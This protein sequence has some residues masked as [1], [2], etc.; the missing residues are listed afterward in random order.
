MA[1]RSISGSAALLPDVRTR[2]RPLTVGAAVFHLSGMCLWVPGTH[3]LGKHCWDVCPLGWV[4][5][6]AWL[7]LVHGD[8]RLLLWTEAPQ[9]WKQISSRGQVRSPEPC[10]SCEEYF[11]GW[12]KPSA[13]QASS[14]QSLQSISLHPF[15]FLFPYLPSNSPYFP[16]LKTAQEVMF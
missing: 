12:G 1:P 2:T 7:L 4:W 13:L 16:T 8:P 9:L 6:L 14:D 15:F 5:L 3:G 10:Y 11:T